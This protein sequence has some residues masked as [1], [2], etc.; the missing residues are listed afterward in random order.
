MDV[1]NIRGD[2]GKMKAIQIDETKQNLEEAIQSLKVVEKPI[3]KPKS[4]QVL[5]R[6]EAAPCNPSDLLFLQGKYGVRKMLPAVPGWE[7]AGTVVENG[8]GALGWWLKGRRVA[9]GG[10]SERDGTWAEY[11]IADA[12]T[13]IPLKKGVSSEQ[14][15]ALIINP[16]TAIGMVEKAIQGGHKAIIQ[17]AALSQVGRMVQALAKMHNI[18]LINIARKP[19]QISELKEAGEKWVLSSTE[20]QF[21]PKLKEMA[22]S[23]KATIAFDAVAGEMTGQILSAMPPQSRILV[24]GSLSEKHCEKIAPLGLIFEMKKVEGFWLSEWIQ[25]SGILKTMRSIRTVQTLI[26][27]GQFKTKIQSAVGFEGWKEALLAYHHDMTAGK[28][29]L[30]PAIS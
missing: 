10:Q 15:S 30:N 13:C 20:E 26:E 8:G 24:Y 12:R 28:V 25:K 18:P 16:L 21:L 29:I 7:G 9:C 5:I 23:L 4:G 22:R 3:P 14:G 27:Q 1:S 17:N 11:Y 6:I 2:P 19:E